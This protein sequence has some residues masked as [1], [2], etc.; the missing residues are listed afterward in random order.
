VHRPELVARLGGASS[1]T[2][3]ALVACLA[4]PRSYPRVR[5]PGRRLAVFLN[6]A[7]DAAAGEAA[8]RIARRLCPPYDLAVAGSARGTSE[9][10]R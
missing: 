2:E 10:L 6:K 9:R 3:D 8:R 7:E 5:T 1:I 4:H